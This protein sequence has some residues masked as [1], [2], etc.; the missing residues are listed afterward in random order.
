MKGI[1]D[2]FITMENYIQFVGEGKTEIKVEQW[3]RYF[4]KVN[5]KHNK[6]K[7]LSFHPRRLVMDDGSTRP[8]ANVEEYL[9]LID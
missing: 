8:Y 2:K 6:P 9:F 4:G 3:R 1:Q 7:V 5:I